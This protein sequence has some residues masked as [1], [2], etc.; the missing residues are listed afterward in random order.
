MTQAESRPSTMNPTRKPRP[1][2]TA[3][4]G[5]VK[6]RMRAQATNPSSADRGG[7]SATDTLR[8]LHE[9]QVHQAELE[10][11][12]E[13]LRKVRDEVEAGQEEYRE[14]YDFAPVGY[15]T[16]SVKGAIE[17]AN[18]TGA[19]QVGVVR[20]RLVGRQFDSLLPA[21]RRPLFGSFLKRV[22]ASQ[23]K[24]ECDFDIS[25]F[26]K[27]AQI[28]NLKAQCS[29]D[30][31]TCR[32][33]MVDIT[34][35][36]RAEE[37]IAKLA[38]IVTCSN[39]AMI[40]E[41]LNGIVTSWNVGAEV[42]FGYSSDEMVGRPVARLI[43]ADHLRE[44]A[45]IM[46]QLKKGESVNHF[47]TV[48]IAKGGR[49]LHV[50][51]TIS[52]IRLASGKVVGFSKVARDITDFKRAHAALSESEERLRLSQDAAQIG[53]FDYD[54]VSGIN[55][56]TPRMEALH[57]LSPGTFSKTHSGWERCL[58]PDDRA[59]ALSCLKRALRTGRSVEG[60]WRVVWPDGS[61]H[62]IASR[63]R[64]YKDESGKPM[65][66]AGVNVDVTGR[67]VAEKAQRRALVLAALNERLRLEVGRRRAV[68]KSL[69]QSDRLQRRLL[70]QSRRMHRQMRQMARRVL[71]VQEEE[72]KRI[73]RELHDVIAQTLNSINVRLSVLRKE[74]VINFDGLDR[75]IAETQ[76]LVTRS[77]ELV[78]D[79]ARELR[80]TALDDIGL[81]PALHSFAVLFSKRTG[82]AVHIKISRFVEQ[83]D[84]SRRTVLYR[85]AQEAL[86]NVANHAHA[87]RVDVV[88]QRVADSVCMEIKDNGR[89][90]DAERFLDAKARG[91]LGLLG[92]KERL[93]M[94]GG[95]F[96]IT[97][98]ADKGT[99]V[100]A[101]VP[102]GKSRAVRGVSRRLHD[103]TL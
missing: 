53:A 96:N 6:P 8:L 44:I 71:K 87:S 18:L 47:E 22:F 64:A 85:V 11:Q 70:K 29:A 4:R 82:I 40:S 75:N 56:W 38:S 31:R 72:R 1:K 65:R 100:V 33:V 74:A 39:D 49:S 42:I 46:I 45:L 32:L 7:N 98:K 78:H 86:S 91:R 36:T 92:M 30:G 52:P 2:R 48:R 67:K 9:L 28:V 41:D 37:A 12:N 58:H 80:P 10:M 20:S 61:I 95:L 101:Q 5:S 17:H 76:R 43:P 35:K 66:I 21:G 69:K 26:G 13:E 102:L 3:L 89:A 24:Q 54:M 84:I 50:S 55:T 81:I 62:W 94:I 90:F 15:F 93:E 63:F 19:S 73:S 97:S 59:A 83:L 23:S 79:F 88:I 57:G 51:L 14:L 34:E 99:T 68:E 27:E 25:R 77:V 103:K 60:E 16:L